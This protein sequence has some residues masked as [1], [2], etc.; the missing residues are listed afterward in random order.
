MTNHQRLGAKSNSKAGNDFEEVS[1]RYLEKALS[2]QLERN[3]KVDI[4]V[5]KTKKKHRFDLGDM[6][7]II[8]C[9]THRWTSGNNIPS[10][11][12]TVWN[13]AMYY[14][15]LAPKGLKK[16]FFV[17][18]DYSQKRKK[19]LGEYYV[20]TYGHLIPDDVE[21]WEFDEGTETH[22]KIR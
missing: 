6:S 5:S 12:L 21:I 14:F 10:A 4:G 2:R 18:K 11:K 19:T 13:E 20:D 17:D 7:T 22:R 1:K 15:S 16:I 3:V 8:E 9:K